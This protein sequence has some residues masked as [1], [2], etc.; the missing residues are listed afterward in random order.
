MLPPQCCAMLVCF[1]W[2]S[3][4][5]MRLFFR[6]TK[7]LRCLMRTLGPQSS[8]SLVLPSCH[9]P[10]R[11]RFHPPRSAR[12][13]SSPSLH[14]QLKS[15]SVE[16]YSRP[17][18]ANQL[19]LSRDVTK[20]VKIGIGLAASTPLGTQ[21][22]WTYFGED[23]EARFATNRRPTETG[24]I[25]SGL[26]AG[27]GKRTNERFGDAPEAWRAADFGILSPTRQLPRNPLGRF[28]LATSYP[29]SPN[30]CIK[31]ALFQNH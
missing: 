30:C 11:L 2:A 16:S 12:P 25:E 15:P 7:S 5:T 17:G 4:R 6:V 21:R 13:F 27:W 23:I 29:S 1:E 19:C 26:D 31:F 22:D 28:P 18:R 14:G 8:H 9:G 3:P 10:V 20:M 24:R